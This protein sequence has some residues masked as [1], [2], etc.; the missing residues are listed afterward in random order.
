MESGFSKIAELVTTHGTTSKGPTCQ[1]GEMRF[2]SLSC[3]D[4]LEEEMAPHSSILGWKIPRTEEPGGLQSTGSQR[5]RC[6]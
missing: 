2:L 3:E 5:V 6:D 1:R 4:P